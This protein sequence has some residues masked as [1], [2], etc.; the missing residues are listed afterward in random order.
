MLELNNVFS[1]IIRIATFQKILFSFILIS[2]MSLSAN[3][4]NFDLKEYSFEVNGEI[5]DNPVTGGYTAPQLNEI[6]LNMDGQLD[7]LVFDRRGDVARTYFHDGIPGSLSYKHD[8]FYEASLPALKGFVK[9]ADYNGDGIPD[10]FTGPRDTSGGIAVYKGSWDGTQL[11]FSL[12]INGDFPVN[13]L[14]LIIN[15]AP[16]NVFVSKFDVPEIKDLD[17][18]G[19]LDVLSFEV[20]GTFINYYQ[21]MAVENNLGL[22]TFDFRLGDFCWGKFAEGGFD[23]SIFLSDNPNE[24]GEEFGPQIDFEERHAGSTIEAFDYQCDGDFDL[25]LGDLVSSSVVLIVNEPVNGQDFAVDYVEQFPEND[26]FDVYVFPSIWTLDA[27]HDGDL[28]IVACPNEDS[29]VDNVSNFHLYLNTGNGC[30]MEF[31]P[32]QEDFLNDTSIDLGTDANPAFLDYNQDGLLDLLVGTT[33]EHNETGQPEKIGLV[34]YENVGD[35]NNPKF[36]LVDDDYLGFSSNSMFSENPTVAVGDISGDGIDDILI[37]ELAGELYYFENLSA[38][39]DEYTFAQAVFPFMDL[40]VGNSVEPYIYDYNGDGLGD[41]FLG[42]QNA[43]VNDGVGTINYAQNRGTVGDPFFDSDLFDLPNS[44][45][46]N[47]VNTRAIGQTSTFAS[48]AIFKAGNRLLGLF[49]TMEG[50]LQ[51]WEL[52]EGDV[53]AEAV[54]LEGCFGGIQEGSQTSLDIADL[55][56]DGFF[57]VVVGNKRG[58]IAFYNTTI[59]VDGT[60]S[61]VEEELLSKVSIDLFPNPANEI[62]NIESELD[63]SKYTLVNIF[64]Q[65]I[66]EGILTGNEVLINHLS[67]G[68]YFITFELDGVPVSKKFIKE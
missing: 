43:N 48:P 53:T 38:L 49:G 36:K 27:D 63:L 39:G 52:V 60:I 26:P 47:F 16:T 37:G 33:G 20:G 24:C 54:Q 5:L 62:L 32:E 66:N 3:G 11:R 9:V 17:N 65:T 22:D 58:G 23:G 2:L 7:L 34:L 18:D 6:D 50:C 41:I 13:I 10:L 12:Y 45:V 31:E 56:N 68:V 14:T 42:E 1:K 4:Q 29:G 59:Q 40:R 67:S 25:L 64:G 15:N 19:D 51:L 28:D 57:E 46:F 55:D 35:Q 44:V 30:N 21:N 61:N 8:P